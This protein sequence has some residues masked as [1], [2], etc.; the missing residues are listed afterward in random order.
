MNDMHVE[1]GGR[2]QEEDHL[3][4]FHDKSQIENFNY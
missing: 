1:E 3:T 2:K 4:L